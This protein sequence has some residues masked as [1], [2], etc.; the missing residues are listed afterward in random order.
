[1][2]DP[3]ANSL[4]RSI[5]A[6]VAAA[7]GSAIREE[8]AQFRLR[9]WQRLGSWL[10]ASGLALYFLD[11]LRRRAMCDV[12]PVPT[13]QSLEQN[14]RDNCERTV[15][16]VADFVLLN[17]EFMNA[18]LDFLNVKGFSLGSAYCEAPTL[19]SQFDL[20]F[21]LCREQA[22]QCEAVMRRL[23]Y[24]T[25]AKTPAVLEFRSGSAS[26]PK[27]RD[28]YKPRSQ[29]LVEV[30]LRDADEMQ[31][32]PRANGVIGEFVFPTLSRE[33]M[34]VEQALHLTKHLR[35][36]W[37]R[38]SWMLELRNAIRTESSCAAF[39]QAVQNQCE[40]HAVS[41]LVGVALAATEAV[42]P[43]SVPLE[44]GAW[45]AKQMD[46]SVAQWIERYALRVVTA[47]FPGTKLYVLLNDALAGN[48]Q[49][50]GRR[51]RVLVPLRL[52]GVIKS[53]HASARAK[54]GYLWVR[55]K[56]H[57]R[58]GVRLVREERAWSRSHET[59]TGAIKAATVSR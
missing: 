33:R 4:Q 35:H 16:L 56:F 57:V 12:V 32:V 44:L 26:Y 13:Y 34:F 50:V 23:G 46:K 45:G 5:L 17:T 47:Q 29:K 36:E 20:D 59:V 9:D 21:L 43:S 48:R 14:Q 3:R 31:S 6:T 51:Q 2:P 49:A 11:V 25:E 42:F 40:A 18:R 39:W 1:M 27:L 37:T 30:H 41:R 10:H 19:R 52:P 58:E 24:V 15:A 7:P 55:S 54:L 22:T 8:L 28:F 53:R 38:A